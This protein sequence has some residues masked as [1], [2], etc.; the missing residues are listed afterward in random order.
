MWIES[1][2]FFVHIYASINHNEEPELWKYIIPCGFKVSVRVW[3]EYNNKNETQA[4]LEIE[5][6]NI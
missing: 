3:K 2:C 1:G 4:G 5:K 6:L